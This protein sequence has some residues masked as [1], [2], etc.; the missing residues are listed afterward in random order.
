MTI[1]YRANVW[2]S[3]QN[4]ACGKHTNKTPIILYNKVVVAEAGGTIFH[5]SEKKAT[6]PDRLQLAKGEKNSTKYSSP[7]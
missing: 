5:P 6:S 1:I 4:V 3:Q 7:T 2:G